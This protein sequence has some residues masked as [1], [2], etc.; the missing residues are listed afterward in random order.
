MQPPPTL[1][2]TTICPK[3]SNRSFYVFLFFL[4]CLGM[5]LCVFVIGP[6]LSALIFGDYGPFVDPSKKRPE[7]AHL[8]H[9]IRLDPRFPFA[10]EQKKQTPS[11]LISYTPPKSGGLLSHLDNQQ[12][13]WIYG[14][15]EKRE[16]D[17]LL[18]EIQSLGKE[19]TRTRM[20]VK[21]Y[22]MIKWTSVGDKAFRR[23]E[24]RQVRREFLEI[25]EI[26]K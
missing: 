14:V 19:M 22:E 1:D 10:V 17:N 13:I 2:K 20:L 8:V 15:T 23:N 3:N 21:F 9:Q 5:A 7:I 25:G 24:P 18:N 6:F 11:I 26:S 16:Q 12:E 4:L